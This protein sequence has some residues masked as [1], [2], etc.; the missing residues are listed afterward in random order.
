M[1]YEISTLI[2]TDAIKLNGP[3]SS[4]DHAVS[5]QLESKMG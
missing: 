5:K 2:A 1:V 4:D 3:F